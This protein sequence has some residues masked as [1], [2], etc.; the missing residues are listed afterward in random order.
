VGQQLTLLGGTSALLSKNFLTNVAHMP[1]AHTHT[2]T[3]HTQGHTHYYYKKG[4]EH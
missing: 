2:E 4:V 1:N 3:H